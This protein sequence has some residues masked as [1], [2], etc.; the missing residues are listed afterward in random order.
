MFHARR[1]RRAFLLS[2]LAAMGASA[3]AQAPLRQPASAAT[4][5]AEASREGKVTLY[6]SMLP[7]QCE[8]ITASFKKAHPSVELQITRNTENILTQ[9][10]LQEQSVQ[11]DGADVV[12]VSNTDFADSQIA[13]G[14]VMK[15]IGQVVGRF[16]GTKFMYRDISPV[17]ASYYVVLAYNSQRVPTAPAT[18]KELVAPG[19]DLV[20]GSIAVEAGSGAALFYDVLRKAIPGYWEQLARRN[21]RLYPGSVPLS[22]ALASGEID[23]ALYGVPPAL[24]PLVKEGAPI[25]M[26]TATDVRSVGGVFAAQILKNAKRPAAAQLLVDYMMSP[27]GQLALNGDGL[28]MANSPGVAGALP[29]ADFL[30]LDTKV[31]NTEQVKKINGEFQKV[32]KK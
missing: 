22:Q 18:F 3:F 16:G 24:A 31:Y 6:T 28:G 32:F 23:V 9:K 10:I 27:E 8:R 21:I 17:V 7:I 26:A 11:A 2:T 12:I 4:M 20:I 19:K 25:R 29:P 5:P 1:A 13:A 30:I 15:P 14:Q